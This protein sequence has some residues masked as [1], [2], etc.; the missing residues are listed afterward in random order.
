MVSNA[1]SAVYVQT[2]DSP[3]VVRSKYP[4]LYY[5]FSILLFID[6]TVHVWG[7]YKQKF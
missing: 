3:V 1:I 7:E 4:I 2:I 6:P 5:L